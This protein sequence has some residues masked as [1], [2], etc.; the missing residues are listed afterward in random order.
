MVMLHD[1][2]KEE[3]EKRQNAVNPLFCRVGFAEK[4][5]NPARISSLSA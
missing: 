1:R 2:A 3:P 4:Y 5:R